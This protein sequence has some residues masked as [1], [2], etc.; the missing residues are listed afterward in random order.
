M[1]IEKIETINHPYDLT[2][3]K[4][5][6]LDKE[7]KI[8]KPPTSKMVTML[9]ELWLIYGDNYIS[10][11]KINDFCKEKWGY[12]PPV[13]IQAI[14]GLWKRGYVDRYKWGEYYLH[15]QGGKNFGVH[16]KINTEKIIE[17]V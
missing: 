15:S 16:Y 13:S 3:L 4:F 12:K 5:D 2:D 17:L 1:I 14:R 7:Y 9:R 8:T 10:Q 11:Y 6:P